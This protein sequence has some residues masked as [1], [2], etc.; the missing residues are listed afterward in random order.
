MRGIRY[1]LLAGGLVLLAYLLTGVTQVRPGERAVIRRFGRVVAKPGPGLHL[2]LPYGM[3]RVDRIPVDF[4][5]PVRVGYDPAADE[6]DEVTPPG[7]LL[8]G[9]HNL[10]NVQVVLDYTVR[11][12]QIEDYVVQA[13]RVDGVIAR[14]AEAVLAE[15]V[16]ERKVDDVLIQGKA[17][18][19]ALLVRRTQQRIA[20]YRLGVVVQNASVSYLFP[21]DEVRRAFDDV[22]RAQTAIRTQENQARQE[23]AQKRRAARAEQHRI[24]QLTMAYVKE[25]RVLA[26]AEAANFEQRLAQY[27]RLRRDNPSFL[28]GL[29]WDE[30]GKLFT[31]MKATGRIDLLDNH[32]GSE[33]LDIT[34]SPAVPRKK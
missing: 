7:Q 18:L 14:T 6:S 17:E 26:Q 32:L 27:R 28:T 10:V 4:V 15:W 9:D 21:P 29:W 16:A 25:Q 8:T 24:E 30:I 33:G 13:E 12:E 20:P 2:G 11:D 19:P 34:V 31:Q 1:T 23:A 22:T 5:R 3:D